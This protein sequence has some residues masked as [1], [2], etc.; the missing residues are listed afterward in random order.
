[1]SAPSM[2]KYVGGRE[3]IGPRSKDVLGEAI[4]SS[5]ANIGTSAGKEFSNQAYLKTAMDENLSPLQR[6]LAISRA[7]S[8]P[9]AVKFLENQ[10]NVQKGALA[11]EVIKNT[12]TKL[13]ELRGGSP[14]GNSAQTN[15]NG[16]QQ[17]QPVSFMGSIN[18][19]INKQ[20]G[21]SPNQQAPQV[22]QI[23]P[24]EARRQEADLLDEAASKL[25][26]IGRDKQAADFRHLAKQKRQDVNTDIKAEATIRGAEI[27]ATGETEKNARKEIA[28]HHEE[29][30][31]YIEKLEKDADIAEDRV[32]ISKSVRKDI[33]QGKLDPTS[34]PNFLANKFKG[35]PLEGIFSTA[36][37][38]KLDAASVYFM[39]G[40]KDIFGGGVLSNAKL[41]IIAKK[42]ISP[43]N[44]PEA[45]LA[46]MDIRDFQDEMKLKEREVANRILKENN[47][48]RPPGFKR[49]INEIMSKEYAPIAN[50]KMN[51]ALSDGITDK[52]SVRMEAPDGRIFKVPADKISEKIAQRGRI[53]RDDE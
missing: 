33:R 52:D 8:D 5:L 47:D 17:N 44:T 32:R 10:V 15:D 41:N 23:N 26:S 50:A 28:K 11:D 14:V 6:A 42:V 43:E 12:N 19:I 35:T 31:P 27:R 9:L 53:L 51:L 40:M 13:N 49:K 36:A 20:Q 34:L 3:R 37:R 18:D 45:N 38:K 39:E 30:K 24:F 21:I 25:S 29:S 1:M 7:G 22:P 16:S 46:I 48:I 4:S 2:G